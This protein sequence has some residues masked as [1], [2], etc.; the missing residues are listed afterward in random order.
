MTERPRPRPRVVRQQIARFAFLLSAILGFFAAGGAISIA[1]G[2]VGAGNKATAPVA[3]SAADEC[4]T[5]DELTLQLQWVTQA[6]FAGYFAARDQ[7]FYAERCLEVRI[8]DTFFGTKPVDALVADQNGQV[9]AD[10]AVSWAPKAIA[11]RLKGIPVINVAQIF[12]ESGNIQVSFKSSGIETVTDLVGTRVGTWGDGNDL[13]LLAGLR[14]HGLDP[15]TDIELVAQS[16]DVG[17]LLSG[18]IDSM[19]ATTGN[20]YAQLLSAVHPDTG[21]RI[22]PSDLNVIY[23]SDEEVGMLADGLW[24]DERRFM[25]PG[26]T[27]KIQRFVTGSLEGWLFCRENADKCLDSVMEAGP[28]LGRSH[29][30]WQLSESLKLIWPSKAGI[31]VAPRAS[32][33]RSGLVLASDPDVDLGFGQVSAGMG[34]IAGTWTDDFV[35]AAHVELHPR[36]IDLTGHHWHYTHGELNLS[37]D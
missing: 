31:G 24:V 30:S 7:G 18:E 10:V 6:Q 1:G 17:P 5:Y 32:W 16:F 2:S 37:G 15:A 33:L 12:Q 11:A 35:K 14:R 8:N 26:F 19:Q 13:E 22:Q 29:Q 28:L 21:E 34:A 9:L 20:E 25:E 36:W 23:W 4:D 27:D 3:A